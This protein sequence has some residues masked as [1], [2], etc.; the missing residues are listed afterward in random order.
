MANEENT[1][2]TKDEKRGGKKTAEE[3]RESRR[4]FRRPDPETA[5]TNDIEP[6]VSA[7]ETAEEGATFGSWGPCKAPFRAVKM[8][9]EDSEGRCVAI[10]G[11]AHMK[12]D[13]RE[14]LAA[15]VASALN[16]EYK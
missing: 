15:R 6:E 13:V 2:E 4:N 14:A 3:R 1:E 16:A 7:P 5:D 8:R 9:V 11:P 12:Q 10:V